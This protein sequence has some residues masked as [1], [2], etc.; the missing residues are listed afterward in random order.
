MALEREHPPRIYLRL[1]GFVLLTLLVLLVES[2]CANVEYSKAYHEV[3]DRELDSYRHQGPADALRRD[4]ESF[5]SNAGYVPGPGSAGGVETQWRARDDDQ[6]EK[7]R[8]VLDEHDDGISVRLFSVTETQSPRTYAPH[9]HERRADLERKLL[10]RLSPDE[11]VRI[12]ESG[13]AAG[14]V[15]D[16][17][18]DEIWAKI[19]AIAWPEPESWTF[20]DAS[21]PVDAVAVTEWRE[22]DGERKRLETR[23]IGHESRKYSVEIHERIERAVGE[24]SWR[25]TSDERDRKLELELIDYRDPA[26]AKQ[27]ETDARAAGDAAFNEAMDRGAIGCSCRL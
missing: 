27:I 26:K 12:G 20:T 7:I 19:K 22:S 25:P 14:F 15:Y 13:S 6:R 4:L 10:E 3:K 2:S 11:A 5:L 8:A 16:L 23:L 18:A 9:Q 24:R 17:P 1:L 21:A